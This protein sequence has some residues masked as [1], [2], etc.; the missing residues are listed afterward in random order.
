MT[1]QTDNPGRIQGG[2]AQRSLI[3]STIARAFAAAALAASATDSN[4]GADAP[5]TNTAW[6]YGFEDSL[7][8]GD[9]P[10]RRTPAPLA[11]WAPQCFVNCG[12]AF[13]TDLVQ[14]TQLLSS[15]SADVSVNKIADPTGRPLGVSG[16]IVTERLAADSFGADSDWVVVGERTLDSSG[17]HSWSRSETDLSL[18]AHWLPIEF[19]RFEGSSVSMDFVARAPAEPAATP[20]PAT[21]AMMAIGFAGLGLAG[22]RRSRR[23]R[24]SINS[25]TRMKI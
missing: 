3:R 15:N 25:L 21:W 1:T 6:S 11:D 5:A 2:G 22:Y 8:T 19:Y 9:G 10:E 16:M 13:G 12:P 24:P 14:R 7:W 23:D 17:T 20:E 18:E 4:A